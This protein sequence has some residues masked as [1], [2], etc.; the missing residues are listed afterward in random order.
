M[1]SATAPRVLAKLGSN[2]AR[3]SEFS[4]GVGNGRQP[5]AG[6]YARRRASLIDESARR[7]VN[8]SIVGGAGRFDGGLLADS[9][10]ASWLVR[11]WI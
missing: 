4:A 10:G 9:A 7:V 6:R 2:T 5:S 11:R 3:S 8:Q 1:P